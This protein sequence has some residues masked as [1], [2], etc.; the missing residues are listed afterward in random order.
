M[1]SSRPILVPGYDRRFG[2]ENFSGVSRPHLEQVQLYPLVPLKDRNDGADWMQ[3]WVGNAGWQTKKGGARGI[4]FPAA[5]VLRDGIKKTQ[6]GFNECAAPML[7]VAQV[8]NRCMRK[9]K[10]RGGRGM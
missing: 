10:D 5:A 3:Q 8:V 7:A 9:R 4:I 2:S 1:C 6:G